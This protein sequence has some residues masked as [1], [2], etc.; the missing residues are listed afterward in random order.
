M[1]RACQAEQASQQLFKGKANAAVDQAE[2]FNSPVG[3][4]GG[5]VLVL[6]TLLLLE[7]LVQSLEKAVCSLQ[8]AGVVVLWIQEAHHTPVGVQCFSDT[9]GVSHG[10][11]SR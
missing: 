10:T 2:R 7:M 1:V 6:T 11:A 8:Q 9:F 3:D 5:K 4:A